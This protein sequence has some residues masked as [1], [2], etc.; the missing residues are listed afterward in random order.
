MPDRFLDPGALEEAVRS[1]SEAGGAAERLAAV[2]ALKAMPLRQQTAHA[3]CEIV[4][5]GG[6]PAWRATA[7]RV[8][9]YHRAPAAFPELQGELIPCI[10]AERDTGVVRAI[11]FGLR[12]TEGV[13]SLLDCSHAGAVAEAILGTPLSEIG[14]KGLLGLLLKGVG[15]ETEGL[16]LRRL[17]EA[18]DAPERAVRFLL[19][20]DFSESDGDPTPLISRLFGALPQAGL[21]EALACAE[22]EIR[23]TYREIWPGI[24]RRG[25]KRELMEIFED[26]VREDGASEELIDFLVEKIATDEG[27][28]GRYLRFVRSLLRTLD[29]RGAEAVV[30]RAEQVASR[31][32][33]R[34]ISRLAE[35]LALL[36]RSVPAVLPGVQGVLARWE[37]ILPGVQVKAFHAQ[38]GAG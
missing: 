23:R 34:G 10:R 7:A 12:D 29:A 3:L 31:A 9:G 30:E 19:T 18:K 27:F 20:A 35:A 6:H 17:A 2:A 33:R 26:R 38:L 37:S 32:D 13:I 8:L 11:A 22:D 36:A 25:R 24:Q 15:G 28:Y 5:T 16:I 4:R 1:A 14:W 21:V